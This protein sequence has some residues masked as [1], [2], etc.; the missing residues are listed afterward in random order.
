[1]SS[2]IAKLGC[3]RGALAVWFLCACGSVMADQ[4]SERAAEKAVWNV[5]DIYFQY[6][7]FTTQYS[8]DGLRDRVESVLEQLGLQQTSVASV[9]ACTELNGPARNPGVRIIVAHPVAATEEVMKAIAADTKRADLIALL[10]RR[11][12]HPVN[13]G[14]EPFDAE[15]TP[16]VLSSKARNPNSAAGDCELLEQLRDRLIK[17][18]GGTVLKDEL[19][20]TPYQ[21]TAGNSRLTV[22]VLI[23]KD[24]IAKQPAA[25]KT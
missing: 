15:R 8:C 7:G 5:Q 3:L 2:R 22:D 20:C 17:K 11:S 10:Q 13:I 16:V 21:G 18:T 24:A 25:K 9:A 1:M 12:K 6:V 23:A 14:S 19:R 4:L